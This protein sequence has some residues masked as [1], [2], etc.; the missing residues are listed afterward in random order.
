MAIKYK[1][2]NFNLNTYS[3]DSEVRYGNQNTFKDEKN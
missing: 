1:F 2:L 3:C